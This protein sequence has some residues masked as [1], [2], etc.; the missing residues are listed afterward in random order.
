M[1]KDPKK[2]R[3]KKEDEAEKNLLKIKRHEK[4]ATYIC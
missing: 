1:K 4:K 3:K 2:G